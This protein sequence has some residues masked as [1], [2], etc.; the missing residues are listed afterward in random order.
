MGQVKKVTLELDVELTEEQL[1]KILIACAQTIAEKLGEGHDVQVI[2]N[3]VAFP[4][5]TGLSHI[6]MEH[7][8]VAVDL[9]R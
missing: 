4:T 2:Q 6:V 8:I 5:M 1:Q 3:P 9:E 7:S